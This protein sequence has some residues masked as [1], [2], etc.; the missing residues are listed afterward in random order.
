MSDIKRTTRSVSVPN[1][2]LQ[3]IGAML[4]RQL[5]AGFL[6]L[7]RSST[8]L[9]LAMLLASSA[10]AQTSAPQPKKAS[11]SPAAKSAGTPVTYR[12]NRFAG[13]A[14]LYYKA[15]WGI[16][17]LTVKLTESGEII[18][19]SWRVLDPDR[20]ATLNNKKHEPSL[21]DPQ[22]GVSLMVPTV[23]NIGMLRQTDA[24]AVGKSYWM[25]FS[26]KGRLVKRG[27]RVNVVIGPFRAEGLGVD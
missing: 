6:A 4:R 8:V 24:P 19:F 25:A 16:D 21:I 11:A 2:R 26:N 14:G 9:L 18:R 3:R 7:G 12:P 27:D 15:V 13:R 1:R 17:S 23:E 22:A 10:Q 5:L 20:A